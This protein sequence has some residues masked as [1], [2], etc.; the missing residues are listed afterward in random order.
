M[1]NKDEVL[2]QQIIKQGSNGLSLQWAAM[3]SSPNILV[4]PY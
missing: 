4:M 2:F 1:R 3:Y